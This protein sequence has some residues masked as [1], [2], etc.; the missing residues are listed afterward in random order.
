VLP[1]N[2]INGYLARKVKEIEGEIPGRLEIRWS[3]RR[4]VG[5]KSR[6]LVEEAA[7]AT[8]SN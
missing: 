6:R 2:I 4:D 5:K 7:V 1:D 8:S 3:T